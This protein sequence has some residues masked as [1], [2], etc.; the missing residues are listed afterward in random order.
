[1]SFS[2]DMGEAHGHSTGDF[3]QG[4]M[5]SLEVMNDFVVFAGMDH[6]VG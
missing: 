5:I 3:D 2:E 4:K 1:M 6:C